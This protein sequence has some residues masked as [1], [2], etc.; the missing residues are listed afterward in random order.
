[1]RGSTSPAD[2]LGY[3]L[4]HSG[5]S[6]LVL[7]DTA[8]LSKLMPAITAAAKQGRPQVKFVVLLWEDQQHSSSS[9]N[10]ATAAAAGNGSNG[11]SNG[12]VS[13]A[14]MQDQL[15][16]CG[17]SV[18]GYNDVLAAGRRLRSIGGGFAAAAVRR[19]DLATLCY[20]SGTTGHPKGVMLTHGNLAYQ[21][22]V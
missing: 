19:S 22:G 15:S 7:H 3:I 17:V 14:A 2:E 10:T 12:S 20:T 4:H 21:V 8:T 16:I 5:S 18:L 6:G 11:S 9:S 13:L 1:M